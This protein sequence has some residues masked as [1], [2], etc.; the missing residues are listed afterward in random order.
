MNQVLKEAQPIQVPCTEREEGEDPAG[1]MVFVPTVLTY[2]LSTSHAVRATLATL[3]D[4]QQES[5][6]MA[7]GRVH[8][9]WAEVPKLIEVHQVLT[10]ISMTAEE[11]LENIKLALIM[12]LTD[13][14]IDISDTM[15]IA[16]NTS[17]HS[18]LWEKARKEARMCIISAIETTAV[19]VGTE[20]LRRNSVISSSNLVR[21]NMLTKSWAMISTLIALWKHLGK[22]RALKCGRLIRTIAQMLDR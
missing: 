21:L 6:S 4:N 19:T 22:G 12:V 8:K 9:L 13:R 14:A 20:E 15:E 1:D 16:D 11:R 10:P 5:V 2:H 7:A 18:A 3:N 17:L